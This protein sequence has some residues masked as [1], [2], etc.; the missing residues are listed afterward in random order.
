MHKCD[1]VI[2]GGGPAGAAAAI[3]CAQSGLEVTV[4]EGSISGD[5]PGESLHPGIEP[6]LDQL[7]I[8]ERIRQSHF[9]R[10]EGVWVEWG[11]DRRFLPFGS[12]ENGPWRGYQAWRSEFDAML[13]DEAVAH[14]VRIMRGC[15]AD[16]PLLEGQRVAGVTTSKGEIRSSWVFDCSGRRHWLARKLKL[17]IQRHSPRLFV[18]Y[19]YVSGTGP[20]RDEM[21]VMVGDSTGWTWK[22]EVKPN[23]YQ[24]TRLIFG[25]T[26]KW[27]PEWRPYEFRDLE[28]V[29]AS[30]A[31][32]TWRIVRESAGPGYW[33]LGDAA[34]VLD[35]ASSHGVQKAIMSGMMAGHCLTGITQGRHG[36][37][38]AI[39]AYKRWQY[40]W[41]LR[42]AEQLRSR[43]SNLSPSLFPTY[44]NL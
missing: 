17:R 21:P 33:I 34:S 38:L 36:E 16:M 14:G 4:L 42:D 15:S 1:V 43:Y 6:L 13:M 12:D 11:D 9:L 23:L 30:G 44:E 28:P 29:Y 25:N 7:G 5:R 32:M 22:A 3:S 39:E 24:W 19:G 31:D 35:P 20:N 41:F 37:S 2:V 18:Q 8:G 26:A 10:H 27:D 40:E